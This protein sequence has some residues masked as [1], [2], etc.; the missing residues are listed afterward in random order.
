MTKNK[1]LQRDAPVLRK[2]AKPIPLK[3]IKSKKIRDI[4]SRMKKAMHAEEDGVAIA[5]PQIGESLR[6]F[7]ASGKAL[8]RADQGIKVDSSKNPKDLVFINPQIIKASKKKRQ[9]EENE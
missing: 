3:D 9:M 8:A 2:I 1:I 7:I 5:A 6:V 4:L